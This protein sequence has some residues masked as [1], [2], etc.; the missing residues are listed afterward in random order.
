MRAGWGAADIQSRESAR[1]LSALCLKKNS[2][3]RTEE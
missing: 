2:G 3:I 1:T